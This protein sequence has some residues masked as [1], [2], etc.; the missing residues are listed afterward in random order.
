MSSNLP[1]GVSESMIPGNHP[2]DVDDNFFL[3]EARWEEVN[4]RAKFENWDISPEDAEEIVGLALDIVMQSGKLDISDLMVMAWKCA[5][6]AAVK[7]GGPV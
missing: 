2:R 4:L 6:R 7:K 5:S 3:I 1:D